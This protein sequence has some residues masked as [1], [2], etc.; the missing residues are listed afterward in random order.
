MF[1]WLVLS[2]DPDAEHWIDKAS[3]THSA[4]SQAIFDLNTARFRIAGLVKDNDIA[5]R[6]LARH[7][8]RLH[9]MEEAVAQ[10]QRSLNKIKVEKTLDLASSR[11]VLRNL[12]VSKQRCA[13]LEWSVAD[14]ERKAKD[15]D[16]NKEAAKRANLE[17]EKNLALRKATADRL[18]KTQVKMLSSALKGKARAERRAEMR[19]TVMEAGAIMD[20]LP[21]RRDMP[22]LFET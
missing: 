11:D 3:F 21:L 13:Q 9:V 16:Q 15:Q 14:Y 20:N 8:G 10:L 7:H 17:L 18:I 12:E 5:K 22:A 4:F 6:K 1:E 2:S 19:G